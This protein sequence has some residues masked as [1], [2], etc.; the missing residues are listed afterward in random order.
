MKYF[1]ILMVSLLAGVLAADHIGAFLL[2]LGV[3]SLAVG[4]CHWFAFRSSKFPQLALAL[5]MCGLFAK[6]TVT[7]VGVMWG[8]S[9]NL[10]SSP[11]VFALSY[12]FFSIVAT[13]LWF[14]YQEYMTSIKLSVRH[15]MQNADS[16]TPTNVS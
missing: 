5:L 16:A 15:S 11:F 6:I 14:R 9:A 13:Y 10:M 2:G 4:C 1:I 7:V 3:S 12:L 8:V